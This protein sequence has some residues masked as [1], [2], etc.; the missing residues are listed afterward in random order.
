MPWHIE[1]GGGSCSSSKWAVIKDGD[2]STAGC[3]G[4]EAAAKKQ[5]AALYAS[6]KGSSMKSEAPRDDLVRMTT[7]IRQDGDEGRTLVGYAAVF[8]RWTEITGWEGHFRERIQKGAFKR[9]LNNNGPQIKVL[10]N[11][12]FDPQIGNK[13]LGKPRTMREDN[14]GLYVEV[15]LDETS[16]N[17]DI[18][19][20]LRSG[21]LDGMSFRMSVVHDEWEKLDEDLPERTIKEIRLFEFGPVT[22]PAYEATTAGVRAHAPEAFAAYRMAQGSTPVVDEGDVAPDVGALVAAGFDP[23]VASNIVY[24]RSS[25]PGWTTLTTTNSN[26]LTLYVRD[27][28]ISQVDVEEDNGETDASNVSSE[29]SRMAAPD[30]SVETLPEDHSSEDRDP[31]EDHSRGT[32]E[33]DVEDPVASDHSKDVADGPET[34]P[35]PLKRMTLLRK[36]LLLDEIHERMQRMNA[37]TDKRY[38][39]LIEGDDSE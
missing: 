16:Y 11:H 32:T 31:V 36:T 23:S 34:H 21:A 15:P 8:N 6:E 30:D 12:G 9:T 2:G 33:Q 4:S 39:H 17:S 10:F 3:H 5:L 26:D 35:S 20:S 24:T 25:W 38:S 1:K 7:E 22:F 27:E 28:D 19:A 29:S 18:I 37:R 14:K 13:P